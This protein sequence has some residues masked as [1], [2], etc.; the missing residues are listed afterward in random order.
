MELF[1][2]YFNAINFINNAEVIKDYPNMKERI[3]MLKDL[4]KKAVIYK[5]DVTDI[6]NRIDT[7]MTYSSTTE[8]EV[9][10]I[11]DIFSIN[12]D[13]LLSEVMFIGFDS[14]V[15]NKNGM[16]LS[17]NNA[18]DYESTGMLITKNMIVTFMN[19]YWYEN[20][21]EGVF[22]IQYFNGEW[23]VKDNNY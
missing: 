17:H 10:T 5:M 14:V 1:K 21:Q 18:Y 23:F 13:N 12:E 3:T 11:I 8:E 2:N 15:K 16:L 19:V 9:K 20:Y 7:Y 22:A 6:N 4:L